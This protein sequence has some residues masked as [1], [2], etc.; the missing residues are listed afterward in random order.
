MDWVDTFL[1]P[2]ER[3]EEGDRGG[4]FCRKYGG[5]LSSF[6]LFGLHLRR[7]VCGS[8]SH[9]GNLSARYT[10]CAFFCVFDCLLCVTGMHLFVY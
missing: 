9:A 7:G 1:I 3:E 8:P 5:S 10:K 2:L 4:C 6:L